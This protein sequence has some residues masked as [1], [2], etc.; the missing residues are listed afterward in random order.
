MAENTRFP[1]HSM[2]DGFLFVTHFLGW[3][4]VRVVRDGRLLPPSL[5]GQKIPEWDAG[6]LR[7]GLQRR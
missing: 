1:L 4:V 7:P 5:R 6:V 3:N 2:V